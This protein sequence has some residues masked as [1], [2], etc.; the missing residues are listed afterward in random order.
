MKIAVGSDHAGFSLK[1]EVKKWLGELGVEVVDRGCFSLE[2]VDY[3]DFAAAVAH[4]VA[5]GAVD[6]GILVCGTGQ[7]MVMSANKVKG[8]RAALCQ[9]T[10]SARASREH[11]D[12]NILCMGARVIGPGVA[13]DVV[14][15]WLKGSF[16]GGRHAARVQKIAALE[17]EGRHG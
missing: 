7:G 4:D 11:N 8:I 12:A 9:D 16:S 14:E 10:F 5:A 6:R 13:R 15:A 3:P 2:S 1:E 17:E